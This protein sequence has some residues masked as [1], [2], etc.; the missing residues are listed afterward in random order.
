MPAKL[1]DI[2]V[3]IEGV[4]NLTARK[5]LLDTTQRQLDA[6]RF[7]C[8]AKWLDKAILACELDADNVRKDLADVNTKLHA[9]MIA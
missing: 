3:L 1:C 9:A 2:Q 7:M 4:A 6:L 5:V 8:P